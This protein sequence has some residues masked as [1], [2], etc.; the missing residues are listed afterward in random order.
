MNP[1]IDLDELS[2]EEG[3]SNRTTSVPRSGSRR[4]RY[5]P[6]DGSRRRTHG[7]RRGQEQDNDEDD[8]DD[9]DNGEEEDDNSRESQEEGKMGGHKDKDS[10]DRKRNKSRPKIH[11]VRVT[12]DTSGDGER[13]T[14][15]K[16]KH[17]G[18]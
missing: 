3:L 8:E 4:D 11:G 15:D 7:S 18:K 5:D 6:A 14:T 17:K 12:V 16:K 9:E 13:D 2:L 1:R 10:A